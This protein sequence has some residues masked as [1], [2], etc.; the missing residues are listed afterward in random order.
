M[1]QT[2]NANYG[3]VAR[4]ALDLWKA[5]YGSVAMPHPLADKA[6]AQR[7]LKFYAECLKAVSDETFDVTTI[8]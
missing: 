6:A 3:E 7:A 4:V 8:T 1:P 5:F 2:A